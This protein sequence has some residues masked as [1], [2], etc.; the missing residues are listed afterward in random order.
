MVLPFLIYLFLFH[1]L[2]NPLSSEM[3]C[4]CFPKRQGV[5]FNMKPS[6][7]QM[8][9]NQLLKALL[10]QCKHIALTHQY[11]CYCKTERKRV[12][13]EEK[14]KRTYLLPLCCVK[15]KSF[16]ILILEF[17]SYFKSKCTSCVAIIGVFNINSLRQVGKTYIESRAA[18]C[19]KSTSNHW[20]KI[21]SICIT[22]TV[23]QF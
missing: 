10:L 16:T 22:N 8:L 5:L 21:K 18:S 6:R 19:S 1:L 2:V 11:Q 4:S 3:F 9:C 12:S 15:N 7:M 14:R 20:R 23:T 13:G 17:V